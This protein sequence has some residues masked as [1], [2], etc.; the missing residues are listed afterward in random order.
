MARK[1]LLS[2]LTS[3]ERSE[4]VEKQGWTRRHAYRARTIDTSFASFDEPC[5]LCGEIHRN[6]YEGSPHYVTPRVP[7]RVATNWARHH[8][9]AVHVEKRAAYVHKKGGRPDRV[10]LVPYTDWETTRTIAP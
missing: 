5:T 4:T 10:Q 8:D 3:R 6:P 1:S 7:V 9:V 2:R